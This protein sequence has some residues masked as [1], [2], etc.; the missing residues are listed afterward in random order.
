VRKSY[1]YRMHKWIIK[2]LSYFIEHFFEVPFSEHFMHFFLGRNC[3]RHVVKDFQ[4]F[5]VD[6]FSFFLVF[7]CPPM[8]TV[9][10]PTQVISNT[11][12]HWRFKLIQVVNRKLF[13]TALH[14]RV[15]RWYICIPKIPI[16]VTFGK[17]RSIIF[18]YTY[19]M[20]ILVYLWIF[21][22]F[23]IF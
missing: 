20:V 18:W 14:T 10:K 21:G 3:R 9:S 1:K 12:S 4:K 15:A 6:Y 11:C 13:L 19:F 17:L 5:S 16:W 2:C 22:L 8:T 23:F 7:K